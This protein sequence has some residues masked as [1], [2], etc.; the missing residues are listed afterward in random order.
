MWIDELCTA[1]C[2]NDESAFN[3]I[4][5]RPDVTSE[6]KTI[7]RWQTGQDP[8]H[9]AVKN[10]RQCMLIQ[11][12]ERGARVDAVHV[13]GEMRKTALHA[14]VFNDKIDMV[15]ILIKYGADENEKGLWSK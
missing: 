15:R 12:L 10:N 5:T 8:L 3:T 6:L 1:I 7:S 11:L 14:A 2:T 9:C 4:L 13:S